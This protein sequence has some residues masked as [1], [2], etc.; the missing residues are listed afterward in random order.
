MATKA[1]AAS[2][3]KPRPASPPLPPAR[4]DAKRAP[5]PSAA[6]DQNKKQKQ[7]DAGDQ[8]QRKKQADAD[9]PFPAWPRPT[10]SE[11]WAVR[12]AL[13]RLHGEPPD[14]GGGSNDAAAA[15][16]SSSSFVQGS[17]GCLNVAG[18]SVLGALVRTILSQNTTDAT[19]ARAYASLRRE[20]ALSPA[21]EA[22]GTGDAEQALWERARLAPRGRMEDS[23]RVGGL[24]DI[25]AARIVAILDTLVSEEKQELEAAAAAAA[26]AGAAAAGAAP[27]PAPAAVVGPS[28][29]HLRALP[30][31][32]A[33]AALVRH[34]GVGPKS[35]SCV[36]A[37][38]LGRADFPVDTHVLLISARPPLRW[39]PPQATR[40]QAYAHLNARVPGPCKVALHVLLVEHGKRCP[41]CARGGRLATTAGKGEAG[42][43]LGT[44]AGRAAA[45]ALASGTARCPLAGAVA[46]A[47]AAAEGAAAGEGPPA[48]APKKEEGEDRGRGGAALVAA[49]A[50]A[51]LAAAAAAA[52]VKKEEGS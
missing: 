48:G 42:G 28:L 29:E 32:Q 26:A 38:A 41:A 44:A 47:A 36:L 37:F 27:A 4:P 24:A 33:K 1:P 50:E 20:F 21:E 31:D 8:K 18:G 51:A 10:P 49:V 39:L 12:A 16:S 34:N 5:S 17:D 14:L 40:E 22:G 46:A 52:D 9:D 30:D 13:A 45:E 6:A 3:T 19:S 11:C 35:A 43:W 7:A 25:K 15:S 23:I 2:L